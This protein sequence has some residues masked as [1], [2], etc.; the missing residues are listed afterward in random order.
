MTQLDIAERCKP[1]DGKL[2]F[3]LREQDI[4]LLVATVP[5]AGNATEDI[6]MRILAASKP[7]PLALLHITERNLRE[8]QTRPGQAVWDDSVCRPY[9]IGQ[10]HHTPL[11]P[12]RH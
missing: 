2:R 3:R 7:L 6:V 4:E 9:G 1:P 12:G 5:S 11:N 10:N 8:F